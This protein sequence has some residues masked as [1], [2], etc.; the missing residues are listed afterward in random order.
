MPPK[1]PQG[2][3]TLQPPLDSALLFHGDEDTL[4][5]DGVTEPRSERNDP[6]VW[7][8]YAPQVNSRRSNLHPGQFTLTIM[9][10]AALPI[11]IGQALV[12]T[13]TSNH[14]MCQLQLR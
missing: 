10:L 14:S 12:S 1:G 5:L 8:N 9:G 11:S 7:S 3:P 2:S 13:W 4:T 6:S